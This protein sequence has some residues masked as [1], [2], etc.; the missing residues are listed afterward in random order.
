MDRWNKIQYQLFHFYKN[1]KI[2]GN[3]F[4]AVSGGLDSIACLWLHQSIASVLGLKLSV[5][6]IHHGLSSQ[7]EVH[8]FRN[9]AWE[10]VKSSSK[11]LGL[12]FYSNRLNSK[13]WTHQPEHELKS[14]NELRDFRYSFFN[15]LPHR[16]VIAHTANDLLETR[17]MRMIR[18]LGGQGLESM[19]AFSHKTPWIRPLLQVGRQDLEQYIKIQNISFLQD[20]SSQNHDQFRN[21]IRCWLQELEFYKKGSTRSLRRSLDNLVDELKD[22]NSLPSGLLG[23]SSEG[24]LYIHLPLFLTLSFSEQRR[25]LAHYFRSMNISD[26]GESHIQ[27]M[28][29]QLTRKEKKFHFH[30]LKKIWKVEGACVRPQ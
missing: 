14:E 8:L 24:L 18:G 23:R 3:I 25:V 20:P 13:N 27:E 28:L 7:K 22:Q 19:V 21:W 9:Q 16:V 4:V 2:S 6:H 1:N 10:F 12:P 5:V 29:K 11:N 17:L 15:T 30:L 26:Y